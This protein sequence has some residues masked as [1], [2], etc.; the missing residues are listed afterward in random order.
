MMMMFSPVFHELSNWLNMRHLKTFNF[1]LRLRVIPNPC[2]S[3][4]ILAYMM[5]IE[6][7]FCQLSASAKLPENNQKCE[8]SQ[9]GSEAPIYE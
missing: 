5:P 1:V 7:K 9:L 4:T 3:K 8:F 6:N 2:A